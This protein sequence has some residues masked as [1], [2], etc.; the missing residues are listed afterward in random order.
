MDDG[1][2]ENYVR[3]ERVLSLVQGDQWGK[4]RR[5]KQQRAAMTF[6]T[7]EF[8]LDREMHDVFC[9]MQDESGDVPSRGVQDIRQ[10]LQHPW[11]VIARRFREARKAGVSAAQ[12]YEVTHVLN[13]YIAS[14]YVE[15]GKRRA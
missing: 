3:D 5:P 14:L 4:P 15:K 13:S 10:H 7:A 9:A 6:T 8:T 12:L 11:R 2:G 1:A